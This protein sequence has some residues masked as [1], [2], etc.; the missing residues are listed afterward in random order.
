[1]KASA[2]SCQEKCLQPWKQCMSSGTRSAGN[3][4]AMPPGK[5]CTVEAGHGLDAPV[6]QGFQ[7]AATSFTPPCHVASCSRT[8]GTF[9]GGLSCAHSRTCVCKCLQLVVPQC[10][11]RSCM[12]GALPACLCTCCSTRDAH[13]ASHCPSP[14]DH[15]LGVWGAPGCPLH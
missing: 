13:S 8:R 7:H 14:A 3:A 12:A 4:L 1:M 6:Q 15:L 10:K 5:S 2:N 11:H 9:H